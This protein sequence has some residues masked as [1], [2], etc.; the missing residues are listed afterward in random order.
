LSKV[1]DKV[2]TSFRLQTELADWTD[3]LKEGES[4]FLLRHLSGI[5]SQFSSIPGQVPTLPIAAS[6]WSADLEVWVARLEPA[7]LRF[8]V[9]HP[10]ILGMM[11]SKFAQGQ[12]LRVR[13]EGIK[14]IFG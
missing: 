10:T 5:P 6:K 9:V 8:T 12:H 4:E 1:K 7:N 11:Q 2:I 14:A 13:S 3:R